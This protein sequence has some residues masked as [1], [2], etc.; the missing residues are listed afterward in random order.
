MLATAVPKPTHQAQHHKTRITINAKHTNKNHNQIKSKSQAITV[1][2]HLKYQPTK[3]QTHLQS[4]LLCNYLHSATLTCKLTTK[5]I[6]NIIFEV[7]YLPTHT[8]NRN[9]NNLSKHQNHGSK[10]LKSIGTDAIRGSRISPNIHPS[11]VHKVS[12]IIP[13]SHPHKTCKPVAVPQNLKATTHNSQIKT[14]THSTH[15][16]AKE[17]NCNS[18][19][20]LKG[21]TLS[22]NQLLCLHH[23]RSL[24]KHTIPGTYFNK[25]PE[26]YKPLTKPASSPPI[27]QAIPTHPLP[28]ATHHPLKGTTIAPNLAHNSHPPSRIPATQHAIAHTQIPK[29]AGTNTTIMLSATST[30]IC[31]THPSQTH[32]TPCKKLP[33]P[34]HQVN[35]KPRQTQ[36]CL[37]MSRAILMN[38]K[39]LQTQQQCLT[40]QNNHKPKT[41]RQQNH[42]GTPTFNQPTQAYTPPSEAKHITFN[43]THYP[44]VCPTQAKCSTLTENNKTQHN[45]INKHRHLHNTSTASTSPT[46]KKLPKLNLQ[47]YHKSQAKNILATINTQNPY[48]TNTSQTPIYPYNTPQSANS[49]STTTMTNPTKQPQTPKTQQS[50]KPPRKSPHNQPPK[51]TH[52][53]PISKRSTPPAKPCARHQFTHQPKCPLLTLPHSQIPTLAEINIHPHTTSNKYQNLH[54]TPA[55]KPDPPTYKKLSQLIPTK[56]PQ[57]KVITGMHS[58]NTHKSHIL[59]NSIQNPEATKRLIIYMPN[60]VQQQ[61]CHAN[62]LGAKMSKK[63]KS[64]TPN[65]TKPTAPS[66]THSSQNPPKPAQPPW[67]AEY[68]NHLQTSHQH[69]I[70]HKASKLNDC[71]RRTTTTN[72]RLK[73]AHRNWHITWLTH[74]VSNPNMYGTPTSPRAPNMYQPQQNNRDRT[75]IKS[76]PENDSKSNTPSMPTAI[77]NSRTKPCKLVHTGLSNVGTSHLHAAKPHTNIQPNEYQHQN[78]TVNSSQQGIPQNNH[79]SKPCKCHTKH[80]T[81]TNWPKQIYNIGKGSHK[82]HKQSTQVSGNTPQTPTK[83]RINQLYKSHQQD[84]YQKQ[85]A[86]YKQIHLNRKAY[87]TTNW[88]PQAYAIGNKSANHSSFVQT[89]AFF[90]Q[91]ITTNPQQHTLAGVNPTPNIRSHTNHNNAYIISM[92]ITNT[93]STNNYTPHT[94]SP[95]INT[96]VFLANHH[97]R[98]KSSNLHRTY[99]QTTLSIC[100]RTNKTHTSI[101]LARRNNKFH[102]NITTTTR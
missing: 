13:P 32:P 57:P 30:R 91:R 21:I 64:R 72:C 85:I 74:S 96:K 12:Q 6:P 79:K 7:A 19:T 11:K 76:K 29:P 83:A 16:K 40:P 70:Q 44:A 42:H 99:K 39:V 46:Y 60:K 82:T 33:Q 100:N 31:T 101:K 37:Y 49:T 87:G 55:G 84:A 34:S 98:I 45:T 52:A 26:S 75:T 10:I 66:N 102:C 17:C 23:H 67:Y 68:T 47:A 86:N 73:P 15:T 35:H 92:Q 5:H 94:K 65:S 63:R 20:R 2:I 51:Q 61:N 78:H 90:A 41:Q 69:S 54:N 18:S 1:Q 3:S 9:H 14:T 4:K 22:V 62:N 38:C 8:V 56:I 77:E 88:K 50:T 97:S 24:Q 43:L 28:Q 71:T 25:N 48:P 89:K 80:I 81:K 58:I 59:Q 95:T 53:L 27:P 36:P 93:P